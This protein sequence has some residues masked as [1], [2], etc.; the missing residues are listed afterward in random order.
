M[1]MFKSKNNKKNNYYS[2]VLV[3]CENTRA[4]IA[5]LYVVQKSKKNFNKEVRKSLFD[6]FISSVLCQC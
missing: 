1:L 6:M 3:H 4:G 2:S 5:D